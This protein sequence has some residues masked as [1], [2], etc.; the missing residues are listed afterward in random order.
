MKETPLVSVIIPVY[1]YDRYLAEAIECV[2]NQTYRHVDVIV[3]DDASTD[4]SSEVAKSFA[5]RGVRY[6]YQEHAGIGPARNRGVELSDG[7]FIAFLD[8][9]DRWPE[10]KLERQ[11]KAFD[12]DPALEM[13]FGYALQLQNGPEWETGVR[14]KNPPAAGMVPGMAAGTMLIKRDA[15]LRV[16]EFPGGLKVG[17]FIDWYARAG[18]LQ[19]RSLVMPDL[20]LWRRIHDSNTG[21]R[22]RQSVTDYARVLKA[23]LDRK[24][25]EGRDVAKSS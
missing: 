16:G 4:R 9:D 8:A 13:V 11:L 14:D 1:N 23:K 6:C 15:F 18:E 7:D 3:V 17:E 24:R 10:E 20:F 5:D 22:E 21:V 19:V 25:A 2:L 12:N